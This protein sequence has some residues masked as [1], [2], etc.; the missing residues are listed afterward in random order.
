MQL[1]HRDFSVAQ[2]YPSLSEDALAP[3]SCSDA[4]RGRVRSGGSALHAVQGHV[5]PEKL[6]LTPCEDALA[7]VKLQL[8]P[9]EDALTTELHLTLTKDALAPE[10]LLTKDAIA[11]KE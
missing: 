3:R 11:K 2:I 4:V 7:P 10:G 9:Y 1:S 6:Q 5:R 8:A